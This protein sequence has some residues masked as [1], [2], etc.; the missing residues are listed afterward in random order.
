M[1]L[2][3][4]SQAW[5]ENFLK[6]F[7]DSWSH[8]Y[9]FICT[10][11]TSKAQ[12]PKSRTFL[13]AGKLNSWVQIKFVP[14]CTHSRNYIGIISQA[15]SEFFSQNFFSIFGAG[16]PFVFVPQKIPQLTSRLE[17]PIAEHDL[18]VCKQISGVPFSE[19]PKR[20]PR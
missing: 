7:F 3:F 5:S 14:R 2:G 9:K 16:V 10:Q 19:Y 13:K 20:Y 17:I 8:G 11:L 15:W 1:F 18:K 12:I 4:V 6:S